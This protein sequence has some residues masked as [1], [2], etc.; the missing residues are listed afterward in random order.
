[1]FT[2]DEINELKNTL[3]QKGIHLIHNR[4]G[5]S[6]PT[7]YKFFEGKDIGLSQME[8]IWIEGWLIIK[9]FKER[10]AKLKEHAQ[11]VID[12]KD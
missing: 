4:T 1:M 2:I 11:K 7:I 10:R 9:E 8:K 6:R 5:V 12:F 3:P